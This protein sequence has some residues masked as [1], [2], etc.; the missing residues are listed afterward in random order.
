[1]YAWKCWRDTRRVVL[2][3]LA[4]LLVG[5]TAFLSAMF[6]AMRTQPVVADSPEKLWTMGVGL[7]AILG[8]LCAVV[9]A[10]VIGSHNVGADIGKG[11]GDFLLTRPRTRRYFVWTGWTVGLAEVLLLTV[12]SAAVAFVLFTIVIGPVWRRLPSP[13]HM[14]VEGH[15][16]EVPAMFVPVGLVA[17]VL[18]GLT[19]FMTIVF[20]S[21]QRGVLVSLSIILVYLFVSAVLRKAVGIS[22]PTIAIF[23]G[24]GQQMLP[25]RALAVPIIGWL[26]VGLAFPIASQFALERYEA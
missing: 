6:F 9:M 8:Y 10:F 1:M 3:Y 15:A 19:Y 11:R 16:L 17:V 4:L 13:M 21:G 24:D 7:P 26:L 5:G 18:Y 20:R 23:A 22:L 12:V 2:I 14:V 25:L